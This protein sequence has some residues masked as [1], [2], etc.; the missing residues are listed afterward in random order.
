MNARG[1]LDIATF[2]T[3]ADQSL[4][5]SKRRTSFSTATWIDCVDF[6]AYSTAKPHQRNDATRAGTCSPRRPTSTRA[7]NTGK[8]YHHPQYQSAQWYWLSW[9]VYLLMF[10]L[11]SLLFVFY[12]RK[13]PSDSTCAKQLSV[14]CKSQ[15]K[16]PQM[17][18]TRADMQSHQL[19]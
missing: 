18:F 13:Q 10:G 15:K 14:W 7:V 9:T 2:C 8:E 17:P 12:V 5:E 3:L 1:L 16:R 6:L 11:Y 4:L 19:L